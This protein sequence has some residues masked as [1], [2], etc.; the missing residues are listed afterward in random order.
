[1]Q[2]QLPTG[3]EGPSRSGG[4]PRRPSLASWGLMLMGLATAMTLPAFIWI[5][6]GG[7]CGPGNSTCSGPEDIPPPALILFWLSVPLGSI[8]LGIL[9][10]TR[11]QIRQ[12]K[13]DPSGHDD[14]LAAIGYLLAIAGTV[15]V[16][17][18]AY[19]LFLRAATEPI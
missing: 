10:H 14:L 17:Y 7:L 16:A 3:S 19:T 6:G 4:A 18:I 11:W 5:I 2:E 13:R 9:L 1:V 12:A 8:A 15:I